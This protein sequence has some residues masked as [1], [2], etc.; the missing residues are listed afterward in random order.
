MNQH[1]VLIVHG[2]P[3][4]RVGLRSLFES[5]RACATC[6][7]TSN[8]ATALALATELT[9]RFVLLDLVLPQGDGVVLIKDLHR[10]VPSSHL[11]VISSLVDTESVQR[12]FRAGAE[13]YVTTQDEPGEVLAAMDAVQEG[14]R[15]ASNRVSSSLLQD[16]SCGALGRP[17]DAEVS[18]L[19][20]RELQVFRMIGRGMS[21][22][23]IAQ[24]LGVSSK[25]VE[26]HR[27]RMKDKLQVHNG[28]QLAQRAA[29]WFASMAKRSGH[30]QPRIEPISRVP[31]RRPKDAP[32]EL[33][34]FKVE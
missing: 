25:T 32:V 16:L 11:I 30:P 2:E 28:A 5:Q 21:S 13:A 3:L 9:P 19:S 14:R 23:S 22:T 4:V 34:R 24:E 10:F 8:P 7:E 12:A 17:R 31:L 1:S 6:G 20:D 27:Q 18:R 29:S 26:T 15:Y 33:A